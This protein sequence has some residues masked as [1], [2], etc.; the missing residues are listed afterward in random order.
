MQEEL[1]QI[2]FKDFDKPLVRYIKKKKSPLKLGTVAEMLKDVN[3]AAEKNELME[4]IQKFKGIGKEKVTEYRGVLFAG[5]HPANPDKVCIGFSLVHSKLD[6]FDYVYDKS[7]DSFIR[8]EGLGRNIAMQRAVKW[9]NQGIA[10]FDEAG[11][12]SIPLEDADQ[13][14]CLLVPQSLKKHLK[15]FI[16]R[17]ERYYQDKEL[18]PWTEDGFF[19]IPNTEEPSVIVAGKDYAYKNDAFEPDSIE[20]SS[21]QFPSRAD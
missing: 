20:E 6:R 16:Q 12:G 10:F 8:A 11:D 18:P 17:C 7:T 1:Q 15:K 9:S 2:N 4:Y 13:G 3:S 21:P 19:L 5:I 14:A